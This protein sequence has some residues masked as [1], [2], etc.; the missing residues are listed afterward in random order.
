[1]TVHNQIYP[2]YKLSLDNT[3]IL[4]DIFHRKSRD[5]TLIIY[6]KESLKICTYFLYK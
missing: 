5:S 2:V 4:I 3:D 1:M 6:Y